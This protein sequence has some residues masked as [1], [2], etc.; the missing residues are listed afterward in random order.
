M[1]NQATNDQVRQLLLEDQMLNSSFN[2]DQSRL[3][4]QS[5]GF[6]PPPVDAYQTAATQYGN[7]AQGNL[8]TVAQ[9]AAAYGNRRRTA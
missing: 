7:Q 3:A 6:G 5:T 4:T 2:R 1:A 8:D 9:L